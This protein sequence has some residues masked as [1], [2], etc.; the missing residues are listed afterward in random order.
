MG[1]LTVLIVLITMPHAKGTQ[2]AVLSIRPDKQ[3]YKEENV[4]LKCDIRGGGDT[5][6][7]YIWIKDNKV[8]K[9]STMP[10]I[11]INSVNNSSTGNYT[12]RGQKNDSQPLELSDAVTLNV[13]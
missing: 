12:C 8:Y 3:V 13:S 11:H 7:R 2:K 6:W 9:N 10:E 1:T 5:V 4:T